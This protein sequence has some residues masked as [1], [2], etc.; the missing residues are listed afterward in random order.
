MLLAGIGHI[1]AFWLAWAT[2]HLLGWYG[3]RYI[4]LAGVDHVASYWLVWATIHLI[5]CYGQHFI[6]FR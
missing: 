2:L 1:L 3:P 6:Y 5:G 4:L